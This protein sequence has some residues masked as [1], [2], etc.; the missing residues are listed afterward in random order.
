MQLSSDHLISIPREVQSFDHLTFKI[1]FCLDLL[2][3]L[4]DLLSRLSTVCTTTEKV[5]V[6]Y[7]TCTKTVIWKVKT[8]R[9]FACIIV[10]LAHLK[11]NCR[12]ILFFAL[13]PKLLRTFDIVGTYKNRRVVFSRIH[14]C[15]LN[16]L[17]HWKVFEWQFHLT[18]IRHT[19]KNTSKGILCVTCI[20]FL[21]RQ[22]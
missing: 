14:R 18:W 13:L 7:D 17:R 5:I 15:T 4:A 12:V 16:T 9:N 2:M 20:V 1:T 8:I 11:V 3:N 19:P 22:V 6:Y 21:N 10:V